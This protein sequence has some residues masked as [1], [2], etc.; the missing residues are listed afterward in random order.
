MSKWWDIPKGKMEPDETYAQTAVRE[1]REETGL[2]VEYNNI[3]YLG[4]FDYRDN[5]QLALFYHQ[6]D[7]MYNV[8]LMSCTHMVTKNDKTF[9]EMDKFAAVTKEKMLEK[10]SPALSKLLKEVLK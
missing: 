3:S 10:V 7:I 1:L 2:I 5:K 8:D 9:P 6:V 4:K